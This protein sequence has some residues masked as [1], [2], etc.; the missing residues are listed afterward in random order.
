MKKRWRI[1]QDIYEENDPE[2]VLTHCFYGE[3]SEKAQHIYQAHMQTDAFM[4]NCVLRQRFSDF[5]C[6]VQERLEH[7]DQRG[8]WVPR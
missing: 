8:Q 5:A 3:T 6:H 2:P 7:L 4:R 1:V